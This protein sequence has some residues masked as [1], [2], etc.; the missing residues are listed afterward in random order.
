M[1]SESFGVRSKIPDH[2]V[3][4]CGAIKK[5]IPLNRLGEVSEISKIVT[6]LM[7]EHNTYITGQNII[8]DGGFT[9]V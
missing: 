6:F 9:N 7:S 4:C 1:R 2:P 5:M 8:I 3:L